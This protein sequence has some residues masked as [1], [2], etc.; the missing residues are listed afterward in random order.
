MSEEE[1]KAIQELWI[2]LALTILTFCW[3]ETDRFAG[4][5]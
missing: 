2:T 1:K 3:Q 5:G 4:Q